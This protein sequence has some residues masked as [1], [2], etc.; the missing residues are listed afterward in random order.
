MKPFL[1][2]MIVIAGLVSCGEKDDKYFL[3]NGT[4]K[5]SKAQMIYLEETPVSTMQRMVLD[6]IQLGK[7]GSFELKTKTTGES[8]FNLRLD[9]EVYPFV[10]VVND[11]D[12]V[13]VDADFEKM[14]EFYTVEGSPA[15]QQVK[16]YLFTSGKY[17]RK[18]YDSRVQIDSL[19]QASVPDSTLQDILSQ[20]EK[21]AEEVK[22]YTNQFIDKSKSPVVSIF[23]LGSFQSTTS[24]LQ[25]QGFN[26]D[27]VERVINQSVKKFPEHTGLLSIKKSFDQQRE[28]DAGLMGQ[29]APE[30]VLPDTDG[31]EV[32][33]SSYK[34]KYVLVDFWASWCKPCRVENPNVV[35]AYNKFKDKNFTILGVSLDQKKDDWLKAIKADQLEWQ[36]ISD[37]KYWSS[38]VVPMY[39]IQGIPYN[40]LLDP[41]G[42]I[43]AENLR[44]AQLEKKLE[45]VLN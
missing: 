33:L 22:V 42:K 18:I 8:L 37:L 3:V 5:N 9:A 40:V 20:L 21:Q 13:T 45:E 2:V 16:D 4:V 34:G 38:I 27:E 26:Q 35:A 19:S 1:L 7:D 11:K 43:I 32:K 31:N 6:S 24:Q 23:A 10:S 41:E 39:N 12:E 17:F 29:Q 14:D 30:I 28:K 15:S 25:V 36:H 44:G